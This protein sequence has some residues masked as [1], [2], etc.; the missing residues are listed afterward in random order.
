VAGMNGAKAQK[1][2]AAQSLYVE[3]ATLIIKEYSQVV[4]HGNKRV[5][6]GLPRLLTL[7]IEFGHDAH[8]INQQQTPPHND[9]AATLMFNRLKA[10]VTQQSLT[11]RLRNLHAFLSCIPNFHAAVPE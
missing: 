11:V 7:L 4:L 9:P 8:L 2:V 1:Q 10:A 6:H 5:Q 3:Y